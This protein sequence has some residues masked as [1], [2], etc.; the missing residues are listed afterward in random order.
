[1]YSEQRGEKTG[2]DAVHRHLCPTKGI[3][4]TNDSGNLDSSESLASLEALARRFMEV[5]RS[6]RRQFPSDVETLTLEVPASTG[7]IDGPRVQVSVHRAGRGAAALLV[8]GWQS[9]ASELSALSASLVE[10]GFEVWMPDLPG[11]GYSAGSHLSLP[12]AAAALTC[13]QAVAGPFAYV[14]G[15]SYGAAS[16]VHALNRGLK[17]ERAA[18]LASPTNYGGFARSFASQAGLPREALKDWLEVVS[19]MI[20]THPDTISMKKEGPAISVPTLL[21]HG[22]DDQLI[23]IAQMEEVVAHWPGVVW[24]PLNK[25]GHF[26]LLTNPDALRQITAFGVDGASSR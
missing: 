23:P 15:H 17:A 6:P 2:N 20:G 26:D 19:S 9:Q 3:D 13:V 8:H 22:S 11:H 5:K 10:A 1:L 24:R 7:W 14:A 4:M 16:V 12:V 18:I 25:V 21:M